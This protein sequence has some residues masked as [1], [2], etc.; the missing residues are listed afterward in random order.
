MFTYQEAMKKIFQD[1]I[2][3][4]KNFW[5]WNLSKITLFIYAIV[6]SFVFSIPFLAGAFWGM[7]KLLPYL[8]TIPVSEPQQVLGVLIQNL[9]YT[10]LLILCGLSILAI[11]IFFFTYLYYL[12]THVYKGYLDGV[13]LPV[14]KNYYFSWSHIQKSMA[15]VSW[16]SLYLLVPIISGLV[17]FF[18]IG[19]LSF[20]FPDTTSAKFILGIV[21]LIGLLGI[22]FLFIYYS[23]RLS[24]SISALADSTDMAR[25]A[26]SYTD[27]SFALTKNRFWRVLA[28]IFTYISVIVIILKIFNSIETSSNAI[29]SFLMS[30]ISFLLID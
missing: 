30:V 6:A 3:I 28:I 24:F 18:A 12:L 8:N 7:Y 25:S 16:M 4:Y 17:L 27:E 1:I 10:L 19:A 14:S 22:F 2:L 5:H 11:V 29:V 9:P 23:T 26:K 15:V 13:Q 20:V 21:G